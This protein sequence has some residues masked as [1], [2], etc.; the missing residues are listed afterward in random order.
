MSVIQERMQVVA[1]LIEQVKAHPMCGK[2]EDDGA[3]FLVI[4]PAGDF[5]VHGCRA[6]YRQI[7]KAIAL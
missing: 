2:F 1:E 5:C 3:C 6:E 4:Y 7:G